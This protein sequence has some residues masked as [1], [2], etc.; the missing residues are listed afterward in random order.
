VIQKVFTG[1]VK[2]NQTWVDLTVTERM[3]VAPMIAAMFVLGIAPNLL[4]QVINPT[5][6]AMLVA[7]KF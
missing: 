4:L 3:T 1:R 7:V 2:S 6:T 5:V